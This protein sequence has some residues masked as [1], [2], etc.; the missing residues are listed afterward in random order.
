[1][2]P[3]VRAFGLSIATLCA[4]VLVLTTGYVLLGWS[5]GVFVMCATAHEWWISTITYVLP[6][7][8]AILALGA[9]WLVFR[10]ALRKPPQASSTD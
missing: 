6:P 4:A 9:A 10:A 8:L 1:M 5:T 7:M 3:K 2:S